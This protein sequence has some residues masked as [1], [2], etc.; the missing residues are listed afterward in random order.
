M[1]IVEGV[2]NFAYWVRNHRNAI[3]VIA[4]IMFAAG[5]DSLKPPRFLGALRSSRY[6]PLAADGRSPVLVNSSQGKRFPVSYVLSLVV[7]RPVDSPK[8]PA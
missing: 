1:A 7:S 2:V 5:P 6:E 4:S 8:M 3:T